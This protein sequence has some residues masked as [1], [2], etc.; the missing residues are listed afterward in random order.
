MTAPTRVPGAVCAYGCCTAE[1]AA[2]PNGGWSTTDKGWKARRPP[3]RARH[4]RVRG[5]LGAHR[6]RPLRLPEVPVRPA[7][8]G[9]RQIRAVFQDGHR[10]P[11]PP[12]RPLGAREGEVMMR[13]TCTLYA[14]YWR[15]EGVL[16]V[17]RCRSSSRYRELCA[18]GAEVV[19]LMRDVPTRWEVC[20]LAQLDEHF[21]PAFATYTDSEHILPRGRGFTECFTVQPAD[22]AR[23]VDQIYEGIIRYGDDT[24]KNDHAE[25]VEARGAAE[26]AADDTADAGRPAPVCGR[27]RTGAGERAAHAG[28]D[29]PAGPGHHRPAGDGDAHRAGRRRVR[30][31]VRRG[32]GVVF[33]GDG[34]A[35]GR[36]SRGLPLPAAAFAIDS[37][38][39]RGGGEGRERERGREGESE[40]ERRTAHRPEP[41]SITL[42]PGTPS[43]RRIRGTLQGMRASTTTAK[44]LG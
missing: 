39:V 36:P 3:P 41:S 15:T 13:D 10:A 2:L 43:N 21:A 28:G 31:P 19:F 9:A 30:R 42:L 17:G 34:L 26:P 24:R 20:A 1:V 7:G 33:R 23:A 4:T 37:R 8:H 14:V 12:W 32:G 40:R 44:G 27:P 18:T 5:H 11:A 16:K 35:E 22:L 29:L 25:P 38:V 6:P